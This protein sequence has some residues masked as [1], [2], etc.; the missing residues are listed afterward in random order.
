[1]QCF[2]SNKSPFIRKGINKSCFISFTVW[3]EYKL[4][5]QMCK[6]LSQAENSGTCSGIE[7]LQIWHFAQCA[8]TQQKFISL[9]DQYINRQ[10]LNF[11]STIKNNKQF[12]VNIYNFTFQVSLGQI[13]NLPK[14]MHIFSHQDISGQTHRIENYDFNFFYLV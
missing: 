9:T 10:L 4:D 1:M 2:A 12:N 8:S 5:A 13:H 11:N 3:Y 14:D 7:R 6:V